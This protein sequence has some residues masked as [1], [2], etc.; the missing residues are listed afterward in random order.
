MDGWRADG[1]TQETHLATVMEI[2][3]SIRQAEMTPLLTRIFQS[4]GGTELMD[5]LMKYM[6]DLLGLVNS[7]ERYADLFA[8]TKE[9]RSRHRQAARP[10]LPHSL[11]SH[12]SAQGRELVIALD[13]P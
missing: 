9:W 1:R 8:D 10:C 2:L 7:L 5:C 13:M 11:A 3:Q 12:N 6:Y 4:E